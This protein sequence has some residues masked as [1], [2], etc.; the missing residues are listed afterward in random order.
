[1]QIQKKYIRGK[2]FKK[3][4]APEPN[5]KRINVLQDVTIPLKDNFYR[6]EKPI[7]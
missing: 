4:G 6:E 2:V 5:I 3:T 1:M 7:K